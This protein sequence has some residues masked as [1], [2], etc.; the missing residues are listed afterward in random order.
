MA[1]K[2]T[3]AGKEAPSAPV[4]PT[5][6]YGDWMKQVFEYLVEAEKRLVELA[7]EQNAMVLK[8]IQQVDKY[9]R[10]APTQNLSEWSMKSLE[11]FL[12]NQRKWA[13]SV[14]KQTFP[15]LKMGPAGDETQKAVNMWQDQMQSL[16]DTRKRW[17][18][19]LLEENTRFLNTVKETPGMPT[20]A[21]MNSFGEWARQ[22]IE[23]YVETQKRWLDMMTQF[24]QDATKSK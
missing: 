9:S 2:T 20:S 16:M 23:S 19:F 13:E 7:S 10:S 15:F 8:T 1:E 12:E 14:S 4:N 22:S 18:N 11:S 24:G 17:L 6:A 3:P 5:Q 21:P